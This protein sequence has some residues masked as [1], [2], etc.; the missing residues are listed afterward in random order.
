MSLGSRKVPV[1]YCDITSPFRFEVCT[2][3]TARTCTYHMN[4]KCNAHRIF[5]SNF[6]LMISD[7]A[8]LL[9]CSVITIRILTRGKDLWD[10]GQLNIEE[11]FY[12]PE[13]NIEW[14]D[15]RWWAHLDSRACTDERRLIW[16]EPNTRL[17]V[18][19]ARAGPNI[20]TDTI[21]LSRATKTPTPA[22][23]NG[24]QLQG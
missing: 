3:H 5:M 2:Q 7:T 6:F 12:L 22:E 13:T 10:Y 1:T 9:S 11:F 8:C 24:S 4:V 14:V 20:H 15:R 16:A 21:N 23:F 17:S 18:C 19:P